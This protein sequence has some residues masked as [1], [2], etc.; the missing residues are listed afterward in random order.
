MR[1]SIM[2][3]NINTGHG[4][5]GAFL[6]RIS[7]KELL[8]NLCS[9]AREIRGLSPDVVCLQEVDFS[10]EGTSNINQAHYIAEKANYPYVALGLHHKRVASPLFS[11]WPFSKLGSVLNRS[12][13]T[14]ILSKYPI[15]Q[16]SFHNF[17][18]GSLPRQLSYVAHLLN[19]TKGYSEIIARVGKRAVRVMSVH[20]MNDIVYEITRVL[21]RPI[22]GVSLIREAQVLELLTAI[23]KSKIP[24]LV[25]G[26]FNTIPLTQAKR[27][28]NGLE[29]DEGDED[30]YSKDMSMSMIATAVYRGVLNGL[31]VF[32]SKRGKESLTDYYTYPAHIPNRVLDYIFTTPNITFTTYATVPVVVSDHLPVMA[33]VLL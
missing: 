21:G 25:G 15:E 18:T 24:V 7:K 26:D 9:V 31:S 8:H 28:F 13:G 33:E 19:E 14:A 30:D 1:I 32:F 5:R 11:V 29:G 23:K 22:R 4:P 6:Q 27:R 10:W 3:L 2:T 17:G 20:T 16:F 12:F